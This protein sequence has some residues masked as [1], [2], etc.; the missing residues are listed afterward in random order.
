MPRPKK[1]PALLLSA[2]DPGER[3]RV[4]DRL[5]AAHPSLLAEA[6]QI[7]AE[8]LDDITIDAVADEVVCAIQG[9]ELADLASRAGRQ[10]GRGYVHETEAAYE[11]VEELVRPFVSDVER[12]A[13][14]GQLDA[15]RAVALGTISGLYQ[16]DPA[17]DGSVLGYAGEDTPEGL[18]DWVRRGA[19]KAGVSLAADQ[20]ATVCREWSL[21]E[22]STP[23]AA[24]NDD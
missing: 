17:T 16:C 9:L 24:S 13:E 21:Q 2:L 18:A 15:A 22:Y 5:L 20:L 6:E 10:P 1:K 14:L 7:A 4:L 8:V 3:S 11:L 12:R 19:V 23:A